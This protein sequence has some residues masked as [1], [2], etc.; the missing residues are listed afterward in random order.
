MKLLTPPPESR[1]IRDR[2]TER[3]G[4]SEE[5]RFGALLRG[6]VRRHPLGTAELEAVRAKVT[7]TERRRPVYARRWQLAV[8]VLVLL[9]GGALV[10]AKT[11]L[12]RWLPAIMRPARPPDA[13]AS[14]GKRYP[15]PHAAAGEAQPARPEP[16]VPPEREPL[17]PTPATA[18]R[19]A[20]RGHATVAALERRKPEPRETVPAVPPAPPTLAPRA[21][22][23]PPRELAP[24]AP[25]LS[26]LGQESRLLAIALQRLRNDHDP[27]AALALLDEHRARFADGPLALEANVTR[28]EAL[29]QLD[30]RT[31]ALAFLDPLR[32]PWTGRRRELLVMRAELRAQ[33]GRCAEALVDFGIILR[34]SAEPSD[35][36]TERALHG[37]ASC[38]AARGDGPGA[39]ADLERYLA[40]FPD[41]KFAPEVRALLGKDSR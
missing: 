1:P 17:L 12:A 41:G 16:P 28:V 6:A 4:D 21:P 40:D 18:L 15:H 32:A 26:A 30:R 2:W 37:R 25:P 36:I 39:R 13:P 35:Q 38:R 24:A 9:G 11:H 34:N 5:A 33:G 27:R 7:A 14:S 31:E 29:L 10:A 22:T 20:P 8:G 23:E 19:S 3:P